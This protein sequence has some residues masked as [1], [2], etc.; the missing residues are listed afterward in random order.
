MALWKPFRG[1]RATLDSVQKH[2]GYVYF[3]VDD[4]SL[5]FD[6]VDDNGDLQRKQINA[7]DAETL[8]GV[9]LDEL[10]SEFEGNLATAI[11]AIKSDIA[12]QDVVILSEAQ[13]YADTAIEVVK[14]EVATQNAVVLHEAQAYTDAALENI[15]STVNTTELNAMLEE[16]LV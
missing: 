8:T 10:K 15:E 11:E 6:Y 9:S 1:N 5:F 7:K 14:T 13:T 3:C 16:V 2:D 4:G 12:H